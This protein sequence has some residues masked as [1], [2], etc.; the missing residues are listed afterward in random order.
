VY[1]NAVKVF[2]GLTSAATATIE[3]YQQRVAAER[4]ATGT[5]P[6]TGETTR[7]TTR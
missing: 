7:E 4:A 1:Y 6:I 3:R 2:G 5:A